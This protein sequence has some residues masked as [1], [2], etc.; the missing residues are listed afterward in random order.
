L[1]AGKW[2]DWHGK[3]GPQPLLGLG[4]PYVVEPLLV[5]VVGVCRAD[6]GTWVNC[7]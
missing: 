5:V 3:L 1:L 2:W 4:T 6:V 7:S